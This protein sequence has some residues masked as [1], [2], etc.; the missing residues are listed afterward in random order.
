MDLFQHHTANSNL[1][2]Y[3]VRTHFILHALCLHVVVQCVTVI[4]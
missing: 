1:C 3:P 4:S 2:V